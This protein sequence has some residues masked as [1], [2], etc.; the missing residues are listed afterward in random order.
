[1][2]F[3]TVDGKKHVLYFDITDYYGKL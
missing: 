3:T 1:M 2:R